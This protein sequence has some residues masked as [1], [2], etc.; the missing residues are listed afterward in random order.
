MAKKIIPTPAFGLIQQEIKQS[1][2]TRAHLYEGI[3]KILKMPVVAYFTSFSYPVMMDETDIQVIEQ[4]FQHMDMK[5]GCALLLSSPGGDGIAAENLINLCR[6]YSGTGKYITIVPRRAK[7]AATM[8]CFGANKIMM[9]PAAELGP[10]D[11]QV[12][13]PDREIFSVCNLVESYKD[14]FGRAVAN[15]DGNIQPYLQQLQRYDERRIKE[16]E[17]AIILAKDI[18]VKALKSGMMKNMTVAKIEESIKKFLTPEHTR[19]HSRAVFANEAQKCGL[20]IDKINRNS[21]VWHSIYEL[22]MRI[23]TYVSSTAAKCIE[24]KEQSFVVPVME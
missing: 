5:K 17:D 6:T 1:P 20:A 21:E 24:T 8:V 16:Y 13:T 11:P 4:L 22:Y 7:S 23:D 18:A 19:S 3:E 10:I 14:L 12:Q 9:G 15:K 2:E